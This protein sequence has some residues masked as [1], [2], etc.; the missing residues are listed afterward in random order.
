MNN[1]FQTLCGFLICLPCFGQKP[2]LVDPVKEPPLAIPCPG[3]TAGLQRQGVGEGPCCYQL[4]ID[5]QLDITASLSMSLG[6]GGAFIKT[7]AVA[8]GWTQMPATVPPNTNTITWRFAPLMPKGKTNLAQVCL[9][10]NKPTW[11]Y[12]TWLNGAGKTICRDSFLMKDCLYE[13]EQTCRNP[14]IRDE[15][16]SMK[17]AP[18]WSKAYGNPQFQSTAAGF[19]DVG[20][21]QLSGNQTNG[22][23]VKQ[24]VTGILKGKQYILTAGVRFLKSQNPNIDYARLRA[25]AFNGSLLL[26]GAHATPNANVAIIGRSGRIKD[27]GD[28]SIIEFPVW[29]A[30]KN[31]A[32]IALNVF[33]NDG[34]IAIL[35]IDNVT[36]CETTG[37]DCEEGTVDAK[38]NPIAPMGYGGALPS[39]FTCVAEVEEDNFDNGSLSDLYSQYDGTTNWY[40]SVMDKCFSIGGTLPLEVTKYNCDDSLKAMGIPLTCEQL[41]TLLANPNLDTISVKPL[42]LPPIQPITPCKQTPPPTDAG[43]MAFKGRDIIYIHGL[44][45]GHLVDRMAGKAGAMANWPTQ[46]VEFYG[47]GYYKQAAKD[48]WKEHI[49]YFAVKK[50]YIN[51]YLVV[52]YNCSQP[53]DVAVHSVLSQIREAMESSRDVVV[54]PKDPRGKDC[55]GREFVI[56]SQS[57]GAIVGDVL[58]AIANKTKTDPVLAAKYGKI[59]FIADYCKGH[60]ARRGAFTGSALATILVNLST[61]VGNLDKAAVNYLNNLTTPVNINFTDP[62]QLATIK[63]SILVDLIPMVTRMRWAPYYKDVPVPVL[64]VSGGHPTFFE[65]TVMALLY[66]KLKYIIHDGFDDGVVTTDC[67]NGRESVIPYT[68]EAT[69][70]IKVFDMGARTS[71]AVGFYLDQRYDPNNNIFTAGATPYLSPMGMV[72]PVRSIKHVNTYYKNHSSY[73]QAAGEHWVK[74]NANCCN[75]AATA[76]GGAPNYEEQLVVNDGTL[77]KTGVIDPAIKGQMRESIN[78]RYFVYPTIKVKMVKGFPKVVVVWKKYWIWK[79]TYHN[80]GNPNLYDFD[81]VYP[82]LFKN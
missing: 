6:S 11:I 56:I 19:M 76:Y 4:A 5:N 58:L 14:L 27:C 71:R 65:S 23:A 36:L 54:D 79:R 37:D 26:S 43:N 57:T 46:P 31:F 9:Q 80:L 69:S 61:K 53:L 52:S 18:V 78:G 42:S 70:K 48:T 30:N 2:V 28:W 63:S 73:L 38:G 74:K 68:F 29:T 55:F 7:Y 20:Q 34:K 66:A 81:Y 25:V 44:E 21:V 24:T 40:A 51:R 12:Y 49:D 16:F 82:Y 62:N 45:L 33:T 32:N 75:Y 39:G 3:L 72:Q 47:Q 15:G 1:F 17:P 50:N 64:T 8:S 77:F 41:K 59:G 10:I 35:Q 60:V 13:L 67:S 22:D